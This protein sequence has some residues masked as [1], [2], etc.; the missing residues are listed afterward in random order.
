MK[1]INGAIEEVLANEG[2]VNANDPRDAGGE[3]M[4][5]ITK[6][7][8]RADGYTGPMRDLPRQRAF[9]IYF[10]RYVVAPVRRDQ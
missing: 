9:D 1:T 4:F 10:R 5:G 8:A 6:A 7:V 2:G 3:T